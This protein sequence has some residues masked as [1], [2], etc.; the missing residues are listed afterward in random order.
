MLFNDTIAQE[1][2]SVGGRLSVYL[3]TYKDFIERFDE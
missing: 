2:K 3:G 1:N